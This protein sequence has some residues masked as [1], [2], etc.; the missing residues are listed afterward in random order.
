MNPAKAILRPRA[1]KLNSP[2]LTS[3]GLPTLPGYVFQLNQLLSADEPDM[4]AVSQVVRTDAS[5]AAQVLRLANLYL[6]ESQ[7]PISTIQKAVEAL[8]ATRLGTMVITF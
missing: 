1:M 3:S 5:L 2:M 6:L 7:E 8:G 4:E